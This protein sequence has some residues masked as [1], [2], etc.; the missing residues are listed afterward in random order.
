MAKGGKRKG[1]GR[2]KGSKATHTLEAE[3]AKKVIISKFVAALEPIVDKAIEQAK[4]GDKGAREWLS[5]R[6]LGRVP[7]AIEV[8]PGSSEFIF[9]WKDK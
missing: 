9:K 4:N 5:E 7:Q 6:A 8:P 1:A 2:K 3:T